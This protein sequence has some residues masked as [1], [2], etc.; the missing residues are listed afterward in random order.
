MPSP[1]LSRRSLLTAT[2][3]AAALAAAGTL[4]GTGAAHAADHGQSGRGRKTPKVLLIGLDGALLDRIEDADA[5]R[6]HA[7]MAGGLTAPSTIA[8]APPVPTS[9]GP[10]WATIATG[11]LPGKHGVVDNS[12]QG[13]KFAQYPDFLTRA[14]KVGP[15]LKT[16]AISS[17][18]QLTTA[19]GGGPVFSEKVDRR[20]TPGAEY[21]AGT[22]KRA[23]AYLSEAGPDAT[24]IQLDN[25]DHAGHEW[26]AASQEYLDAL[27]AV[28]TQVGTILDAVEGRS[29]YGDE[30]WLVMVTADHGHTD[31]GG[32]GGFTEP[33]KA[34]FLIA[35]G[36]GLTPGSTRTDASMV[37]IAPTA[38]T[39]LG[40]TVAGSWGLDGRSLV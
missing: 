3:S 26:G 17:W 20:D 33:E 36:A 13:Q 29:S 2:A 14:E 37:D 15:A 32:H 11:V 34:T 21:D 5:P 38:L 31:A 12:F 22:T 1:G 7:L 9:S 6:L 35:N 39:H 19:T 16:Y 4:T 27:H 18:P 10:G 8:Y 40:I 23:A 25:V 28:D 30:D 24:F